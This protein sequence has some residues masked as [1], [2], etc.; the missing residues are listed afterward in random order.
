MPKAFNAAQPAVAPRPR[1]RRCAPRCPTTARPADAATRAAPPPPTTP[2]SPGCARRI[3]GAPLPRLRRARGP[4]PLGRALPPAA[5]ARPTQLEQRVEQRTNTIARTVRPGLRRA[6]VRSATSTATTRHR[7]TGAR[8]ARLY[9]ELDLLAAECLRDGLWDGLTPAELAA[10]R[11]GAGLRVAAARRRRA[12]AA[13]RRARPRGAGRDG[14][15]LGPSSTQ[16]ES[17]HRLAFLREPDLG[18]AWAA[19]RWAA[20]AGSTTCWARPT[21]RPAT[22]SAGPSSCSTC[23]A[24]SRRPRH[25]LG[26]A[27]RAGRRPRGEARSAAG[28]WPT[29]RLGAVTRRGLAI[30]RKRRLRLRRWEIAHPSPRGDP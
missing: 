2:R 14:A 27:S 3:R 15:H 25:V 24:R 28:S 7:P 4:R 8:L 10:V 23:S 6:R 5:R 18:F 19:Y 30:L 21:W 16:L 12:P 1:R 11:V 20:G 13:A 17:D 9:T 26:P 29:R 22:S